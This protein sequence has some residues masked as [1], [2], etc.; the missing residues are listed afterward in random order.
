[1]Q[2]AL[3]RIRDDL[4]EGAEETRDAVSMVE[5]A[6]LATSISLLGI[7][8]RAGSMAAAALTS[9]P[10]WR[11]VDPLA[12]LS[13]SEEEREKRAQEMREA[14]EAE[15]REGEGVGQLLDDEK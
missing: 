3:D 8:S 12:V 1:M 6:T 9:L 5:G 10:M 7:L 15:D 4:R 13:V 2:D 11:R 14:E